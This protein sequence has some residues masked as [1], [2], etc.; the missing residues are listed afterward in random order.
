MTKLGIKR[1]PYETVLEICRKVG[2]YVLLC[3]PQKIE[4]RIEIDL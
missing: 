2:I 3:V 1:N 4:S